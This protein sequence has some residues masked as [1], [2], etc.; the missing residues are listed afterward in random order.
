MCIRTL[1]RNNKVVGLSIN[2]KSFMLEREVC[3]AL[4]IEE[5]KGYSELKLAKNEAEKIKKEL[6]NKFF[7]GKSKNLTIAVK[8]NESG[9]IDKDSAQV[10][11]SAE[12]THIDEIKKAEYVVILDGFVE[13]L[14]Q[15]KLNHSDEAENKFKR[16]IQKQ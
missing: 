1:R 13:A 8:F 11:F 16:L 12:L 7:V 5:T 4:G 3:H 10:E 9:D 6:D 14:N 2:G 15:A